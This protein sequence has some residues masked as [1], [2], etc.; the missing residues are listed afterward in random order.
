MSN[1][2]KLSGV[3]PKYLY[4]KLLHSLSYCNYFYFPG[5]PLAIMLTYEISPF[6]PGGSPASCLGPATLPNGQGL[7]AWTNISQMS[8]TCQTLFWDVSPHF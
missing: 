4:N 3:F 1:F 8:A 2:Y 7:N 5:C 6:W